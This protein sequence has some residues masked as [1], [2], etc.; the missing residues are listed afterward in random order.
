MSAGQS[1]REERQEV[2][3]RK[4]A[5]GKV[6]AEVA[7]PLEMDEA[8]ARCLQWEEQ[9]AEQAWRGQHDATLAVVREAAG[10]LTLG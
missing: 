7:P 5:R 2:P 6:C 3:A 4:K 8:M 9:E 10:P 1:A